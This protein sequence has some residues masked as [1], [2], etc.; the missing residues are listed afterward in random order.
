MQANPTRVKQEI[1]KNRV[2]LVETLDV[3]LFEHLLSRHLKISLEEGTDNSRRG[4]VRV[5]L[6]KLARLPDDHSEE[7][8]NVLAGL[9]PD[10][11]E[12]VTGREPSDLESGKP[13]TN[14]FRLDNKAMITN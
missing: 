1:S 10:M 2:K 14:P 11:F 8:A 7:F 4:K 5:I 9:Y 6:D 13:T 12:K 3:C